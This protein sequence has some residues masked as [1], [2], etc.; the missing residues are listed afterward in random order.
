MLI[1]IS[2]GTVLIVGT[3]NKKTK[4]EL[5]IRDG[6]AVVTLSWLFMACFSALPY[7]FSG[8]IN[9]ILNSLYAIVAFDLIFLISGAI[10]I[11]VYFK[12]EK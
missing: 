7:Y 3:Y 10:L 11:G 1:T 4:R 9:Y 6:Y 5:S 2:A 8:N 12:L